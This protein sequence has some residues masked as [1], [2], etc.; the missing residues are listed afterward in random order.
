MQQT[1]VVTRKAKSG[2][3]VYLPVDEYRAMTLPGVNHAKLGSC[4][5]RV[6]DLPGVLDEYMEVNPRVPNRSKKGI[7]AGPVAKGILST[8]QDSPA[9]MVLKNQGIYLLVDSANFVLGNK[10]GMLHLKFTDKGK[11][12]IVNGGHTYAAIREAIETADL[13]ELKNLTNAYV[14]LH[15]F[16]GIEA[17]FVPEI[18][19][20]LNR[21]KQVDDPSLVNLQGEF[22][23]IRKALKGVRGE[24]AIAYHQGDEGSIYISELLVYISMFNSMRFSETYHPNGLYNRNSL[25]LKYFIEDMET[26]KKYV[27]QLIEKLPDILWLADAIRKATPEAAKKNNFK[28]GMA[29]IGSERAG[30]ATQK[31][32]YLPFLGETINYRVP[33]GWVYPVLAAF[34]A[35]LVY[36]NGKA[37]WLIPV[38][39]LLP[40]V[41][42]SLISVCIAE[43]KANNARP[44]LIGKR[45][46][47]YSQCY[48][49]LQLFLAKKNLLY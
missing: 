1:E 16:Q 2:V 32:T 17:D 4:F 13:P 38:K 6:L 10:G 26:D 48:T 46:S 37:N 29:K 22:D 40:Q 47:A 42:N 45:E 7:L 49:K 12:G 30:G 27:L 18:A 41:I 24:N 21:S 19:E 9:D 33:N 43:H 44:E 3:D 15:I 25:G 14:R 31:G 5:V 35:N 8:L 20:G 23:V 11:H 36:E 34:R 28:F 39:D